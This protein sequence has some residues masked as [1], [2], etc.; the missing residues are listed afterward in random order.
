[1][2]ICCILVKL[3]LNAVVN[4]ADMS[5]DIPMSVTTLYFIGL[6]GIFLFAAMLHPL[7]AYCLIHGIWYLLCLPSGYLV[8]TIYSICNITD[9]SWGELFSVA[10]FCSLLTGLFTARIF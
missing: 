7:E 5:V 4:L 10:L 6:T 1:M 2:L 9:S 8:L 3:S